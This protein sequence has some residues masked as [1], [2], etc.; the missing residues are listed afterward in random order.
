MTINE[1]AMGVEEEGIGY[2]ITSY[3][4]ANSMPTKELKDA[5][6]E[7]ETA[8]VAFEALLPKPNYDEE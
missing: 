1:V 6:I 3:T 2:F 5:F 7:V 4:S 8:I